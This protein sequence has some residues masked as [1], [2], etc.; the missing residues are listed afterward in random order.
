MTT[1]IAIF[2][3]IGF[4]IA[5]L[6]FRAVVVLAVIAVLAM[7]IALAGMAIGKAGDFKRRHFGTHAH[8]VAHARH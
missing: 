7:P 8:V 4:F 1:T 2:E 6:A 5:G 3:A